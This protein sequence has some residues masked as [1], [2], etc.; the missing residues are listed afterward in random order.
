M[1]YGVRLPVISI[2]NCY[3]EAFV[4]SICTTDLLV[5]FGADCAA[6]Q[7]CTCI[8][9]CYRPFDRAALVRDVD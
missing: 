7:V 9:M 5:S 1:V 8:C 3:L 4:N 6:A 2:T